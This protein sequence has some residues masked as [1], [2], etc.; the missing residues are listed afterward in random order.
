MS[1][2]ALQATAKDGPGLS[3]RVVRRRNAVIGTGSAS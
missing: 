3:A 2:E 1:N